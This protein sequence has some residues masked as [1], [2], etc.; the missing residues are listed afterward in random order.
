M[1]SS[2][3][4]RITGSQIY[5]L[6]RMLLQ[7][8]QKIRQG[9]PYIKIKNGNC[10]SFQTIMEVLLLLIQS[11]QYAQPPGCVGARALC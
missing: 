11:K 3:N 8:S 5:D 9:V 7:K 1:A 2:S 10:Y 6:K 4:S